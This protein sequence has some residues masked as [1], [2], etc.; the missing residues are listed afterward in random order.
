[1]TQTSLNYTQMN[2][3]MLSFRLQKISGIKI[4]RDFGPTHFKKY[5]P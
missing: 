5:K 3:Y 1:M 2:N 4:S